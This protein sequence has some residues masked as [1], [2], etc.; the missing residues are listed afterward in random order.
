[1]DFYSLVASRYLSRHAAHDFV[2]F[3]NELVKGNS[4]NILSNII[5]LLFYVAGIQHK[6]RSHK[7]LYD[8]ISVTYL[9]K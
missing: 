5:T 1:M 8:R 3:A 6:C 9:N 7:N 2:I 4:N